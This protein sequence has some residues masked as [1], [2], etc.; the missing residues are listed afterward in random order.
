MI[1]SRSSKLFLPKRAALGAPA[2]QGAGFNLIALT[3]WWG[4]GFAHASPPLV[5]KTVSIPAGPFIQGSDRIERDAGYHLDEVAYGHR[6][7]RQDNWYENELPRATVTTAAYNITETAITN[8]E[9]AAFVSATG[10]RAP[11][12]DAPTWTSYG[13]IHPYRRTRR[14]TW[15]GGVPPAKREHHPVVLVSWDDASA[16]A[17]WL[18]RLTGAQWRLPTEEQ[19]EKA[20]RGADGRRFPWGD[21]F[22]P[23]RLNSHD[24]GPFDTVPAGKFLSGA[25]PYGVL[26]AAGQVFE[27]TATSAG[28]ERALVKGGSWDDSGCGICRPAARHT[29]ARDLKHILIGFRLIQL[30]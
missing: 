14:H 8:A 3:L 5:P 2:R 12:V 18:S 7:T 17:R 22:D 20:A 25:S 11:D 1:R 26:D 30:N 19:W 6:V 9:Y 13:L 10:H 4:C 24:L 15:Q 28:P 21:L 23:Y 27:W 16:Y 29:R